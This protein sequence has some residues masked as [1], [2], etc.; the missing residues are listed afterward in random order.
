[1]THGT[2]FADMS[3]IF[4][5][6][7]GLIPLAFLIFHMYCQYILSKKMNI[8]YSWMAW[9]PVLNVF[10]LVKIAGLSYWWILGIFI[11]L[12]NIYVVIKIYHGIS[13]NTG[14]WGWW[15]VGL[16]FSGWILMPVTAFHYLPGDAITPRPFTGWRKVILIILSGFWVVLMPLWI[17]AAALFPIMTWYLQASRD[18]ARTS[19]VY[20]IRTWLNAYYVDHQKYPDTDPSGCIPIKDI[21]WYLYWRVTDPTPD[22]IMVGCDGSNGQSY[23][24]R[25]YTDSDWKEHYV[26]WVGMERNDRAKGNSNETNINKIN[27][28]SVMKERSWP[29]YYITQ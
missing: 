29:Y 5:W 15:T 23:A 8:Q 28:D 11:P 20:S 24:Y 10:N 22:R 1:M 21:Q 26:V 27:A 6:V 13:K 3:G 14:H 18:G 25:K 12:W 7:V 9:I 19:Q 2:S 17:I 4:T 16:I